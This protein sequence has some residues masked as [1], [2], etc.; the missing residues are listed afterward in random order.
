MLLVLVR[1][2]YVQKPA[3]HC[4]LQSG[5]FWTKSH[6]LSTYAVN[7]VTVKR[8]TTYDAWVFY[9]KKESLAHR[10]LNNDEQQ[11]SNPRKPQK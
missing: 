8:A 9:P 11:A 6:A 5:Y 3:A 7:T 1:F 2:P 10:R 4:S